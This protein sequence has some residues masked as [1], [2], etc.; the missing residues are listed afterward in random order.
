MSHVKIL[1]PAE[2]FLPY[3]QAKL[4]VMESFVKDI[5]RTLGT[6]RAMFDID[7]L[8]KEMVPLDKLKWKSIDDFL[9]TVS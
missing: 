5:E 1:F 9:G 2:R 7:N 6:E 3:P 4:D 8:W